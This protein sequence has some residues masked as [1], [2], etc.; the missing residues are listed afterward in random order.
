MVRTDQRLALGFAHTG[1]SRAGVVLITE[2]NHP[3]GATVP[4]QP[5]ALEALLSRAALLCFGDHFAME[6]RCDLHL[7][8]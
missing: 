4:S 2:Q 5:P 3:N 1:L 8:L 6:D 7:S